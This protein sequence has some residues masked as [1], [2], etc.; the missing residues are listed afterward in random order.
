MSIDTKSTK[1]IGPKWIG[2]IGN[3]TKEIG[4]IEGN[5]RN[6]NAI[7]Q[8][9]GTSQSNFAWMFLNKF[10]VAK[11]EPWIGNILPFSFYPYPTK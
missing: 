5:T 8:K 2:K 7:G 11:I 9:N 10:S 1:I 4:K 6:E 3:G